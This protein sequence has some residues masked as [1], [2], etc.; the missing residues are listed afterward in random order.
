MIR[1]YLLGA[2]VVAA[3]ATAACA[4]D[5]AKCEHDPDRDAEHAFAQGKQGWEYTVKLNSIEW[6]MTYISRHGYGEI[7]AADSA[8]RHIASG[9]YD[10]GTLEGAYSC[11]HILLDLHRKPWPATSAERIGSKCEV[12][13]G[14][15]GPVRFSIIR[16]LTVSSVTE[17]ISAGVLSG[18]AI[19]YT[20]S[21]DAKMYNLLV[22]AATDGCA[23]FE[24]TII[25]ESDEP[26]AAARLSDLLSSLSI[27]KKAYPVPD[28]PPPWRGPTG[29]LWDYFEHESKPRE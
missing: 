2:L 4:Q 23:T 27:E 21:D 19:H 13:E 22:L 18:Y 9:R 16:D 28:P 12:V 5:A 26:V 7:V 24:T 11:R 1:K 20:F 15:F 6:E 25:D 29:S 3:M 10:F 8:G 14:N 17:P